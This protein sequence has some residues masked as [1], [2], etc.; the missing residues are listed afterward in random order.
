MKP[1]GTEHASTKST[2]W[3]SAGTKSTGIKPA[4]ILLATTGWSPSE[5]D[6][7]SGTKSRVRG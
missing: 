2:S 1:A 6:V 3:K 7:D 4:G 5:A